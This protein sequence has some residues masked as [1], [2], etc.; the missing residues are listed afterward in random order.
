MRL[1]CQRST[2]LSAS[3]RMLG[4]WLVSSTHTRTALRRERT[5]AKHTPWASATIRHRAQSTTTIVTRRA[6]SIE[7]PTSRNAFLAP[8]R[9]SPRSHSCPFDGTHPCQAAAVRSPAA[10]QLAVVPSGALRAC[11]G[12]STAPGSLAARWLDCALVVLSE[13]ALWPHA[14]AC[15][16]TAAI[17]HAG[18]RARC[19]RPTRRTYGEM[20]SGPA[21]RDRC[22]SVIAQA[23]VSVFSDLMTMVTLVTWQLACYCCCVGLRHAAADFCSQVW[24][25]LAL[26]VGLDWDSSGAAA[27]R[28]ARARSGFST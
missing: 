16:C 21:I 14:G 15:V 10:A 2:Y 12:F 22:S 18:G 24:A 8:S 23:V 28:E 4:R 17:Y 9:W 11:P 20:H 6:G 13:R 7:S 5:I 19:D 3:R 27:V 26:R 1:S 25:V